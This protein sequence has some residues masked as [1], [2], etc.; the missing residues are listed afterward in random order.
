MKKGV[1]YA[2]FNQKNQKNGNADRVADIIVLGVGTC[3][4]DLS[5]QLLKAGKDVIGIEANL[6]GGECPYWACVPSKTMVRAAKTLQ[7][8][9]RV[10]EKSGE[11]DVEPDWDPVAKRVRWITGSWD[12]STAIKRYQSY[13]GHMVKGWG[14]L[15]GPKTVAVGDQTFTA[16]QG[17]VIATGSKPF[18]PPIK[19]IDEVDYWTTHDLIAMENLPESL[20]VIGGGASGC[21]LGQV[22]SRF[23]T[24][25]TVIE[26]KSHL[27]PREEPEVAAVLQEAFEAEGIE[28]KTG[29]RAEE[30]A[31]EN[32]LIMVTLDDGT[33]LEA[34]RVLIA[35]GRR[36]YMSDLGL[37]TIGLDPDA[38]FIPVDER[39]RVTDGIW[40]MGD[41]TGKSLLTHV[42]VYQGKIIAADIL[43]KEH[44][45]AR[46]DA[47]PRGTFTDPEVA[48]VGLTESEISNNGNDPVVVIKQMPYTFRGVIDGVERGVIKLV[49]DRE[50]G[51]L[52]GGSV[53]GPNATDMLGILNLAV[54][55]KIPLKELRT[56]IYA[57]PAFYGA[58]GE[59]IGAWGQGV[60]LAID[61]EYEGVEVIN[62]LV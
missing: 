60:I 25:V 42:A 24:D 38:P 16:K 19:R 32:G 43:G 51:I 45:P 33:Q 17:I 52:V 57:F 1:C 53:A 39:M 8:A 59:A 48:S 31:E 41:V 20:I 61:P 4:E 47:I 2:I 13:G 29:A 54:H 10:N 56:M 9:R 50:E 44:P 62:N 37:E 49:I 58:I 12:D 15:I 46:Y 30:V 5:L 3:G 11:A 21:E 26:A 36:I 35:A 7:E 22:V 40:A 34:E 27:L 18:I 14:K 23:G 55:A 28:V 6:V